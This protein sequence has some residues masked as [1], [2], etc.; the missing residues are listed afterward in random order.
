MKEDH[1]RK[2]KSN[3]DDFNKS[4]IDLIAKRVAYRCC[5]KG[6][7]IATIGP[8]Y[9]DK[10]KTTSIGVAC[11]ICAASPNG[12][13][14]DASMTP[15]QRKSADNGIWMCETH[16][17]LIDKDE[18]KYPV[19]V[20]REWKLAAEEMA[21]KELGNYK[22]TKV[23]LSD[24]Y[25]LSEIFKKFIIDGDYDVLLMVINE[26]KR[27][28][29][30]NEFILRYEV[31]YNAYCNREALTLS[32]EYYLK[33]VSERK[34]DEI[35]KV[36]VALNLKLGLEQLLPFCTNDEIKLLAKAILEGK[37]KNI[38]IRDRNEKSEN[39]IIHDSDTASK[40]LSLVIIE[41][42][43]YVL[44][45][46]IDGKKFKLV[47]S[48][49]LFKIYAHCWKLN[50]LIINNKCF[51]NKISDCDDYQLIKYSL[52]KIRQ[53]DKTIQAN[54]W[55]ICL[56]FVLG[57]RTEFEWLFMQC[58]DYIKYD[59]EVKK[60]YLN[61]QL[62]YCLV[63]PKDILLNLSFELDDES[64]IGVLE[65]VD[66]VCRKNFLEE[67]K[68]LLKKNS[69]FLYIWVKLINTTDNEKYKIVKSYELYYKNNF[70][71]NCMVALYASEDEQ[72]VIN[73][74]NK[75]ISTYY[76]SDIT[77][78]LEVLKKY[79]MWDKIKDLFS[80]DF[81]MDIKYSILLTL[82]C[83]DEIENNKHCL[84]LFAYLEKE[85][86]KTKG[87]Y[88]NYAVL[89][90]RL[91]ELEKARGCFQKEYDLYPEVGSLINL[92][93]SRNN[94]NYLIIDKYI[95]DACKVINSQVQFLVA[96]T[97]WRLGDI[98][99]VGEYIIRALL[100]DPNNKDALQMFSSYWLLFPK[101]DLGSVYTLQNDKDNIRIALLKEEFIS[102]ING[103]TIF[104][105]IVYN[106]SSLN[107]IHWK[108]LEVN[109]EVVYNNQSYKVI[110]IEPFFAILGHEAFNYTEKMGTIKAIRGNSPEDALLQ[111]KEIMTESENQ[112][113][114][115]FD[116]FN[117][118]H[119]VYPITM[120]SAQLGSCFYDTWR[121]V[122]TKNNLKIN[123]YSS[124]TSN[125]TFI[126]SIDAACTF[127][128]L[129]V[130][131]ELCLSS[132]LFEEHTKIKLVNILKD[133]IRFLRQDNTAGQLYCDN[134]EI[135]RVTYDKQYKKEACDNLARLI[136]TISNIKEISSEA[137]QFSDKEFDEFFIEY[138]LSTES[139]VLCLA[140]SNDYVI[141]TDE[142][143]MRMMCDKEH[144]QH[145]SAIELLLKNDLSCEKMFEYL[146]KI[147][148]TNFLNYFNINTLKRMIN[149]IQSEEK[150]V[151]DEIKRKIYKW[152]FAEKYSAE[153]AR[154]IFKACQ[155]LIKQEPN[156]KYSDAALEIAKHYFEELFPDE[157]RRIMGSLSASSITLHLE[158]S[159]D[160]SVDNEHDKTEE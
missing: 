21:A 100:I 80:L 59:S 17:H 72:A 41:N 11:H 2:K 138:E 48:E 122:V 43:N 5:Y 69:K 45:S 118:V 1:T 158:I 81:P 94:A 136:S 110:C 119:G 35:L 129:N 42:K 140:K 55:Y 105:I 8:K 60:T 126:L 62:N 123:N 88:Y 103:K 125:E 6:C 12:P 78:Y 63:D 28:D 85:G 9:G 19:E 159:N 131:D 148:K 20:L 114:T 95:D 96:L 120:L 74:L 56:N 37:V 52:S 73:W 66:D 147:E 141:V 155:E 26:L 30:E 33:H 31:I 76:F 83:C 145:V 32:I 70:L 53:L 113:A 117:Q 108:F 151:V 133:K 71:W 112:R 106:A 115:I 49:F 157:Y 4:T 135:K 87:F 144:I 14:Y 34:C 65:I 128:L 130:F 86:Y 67:H 116:I 154:N 61:Y 24:K 156:S 101:E 146:N 91:N 111:I 92:L 47:D 99:R 127:I 152:F 98:S 160:G 15:A 57:D 39:F 104:N 82:C 7:G 93:Q 153:H 25:F 23:Q 40:L 3:R 79:K 121:Y 90:N 13:R 102:G 97:Y 75:G 68:Y 36:L 54:V 18:I 109:D 149:Y 107:F 38:L 142:P 143:F 64:L 46:T 16:S 44:P 150:I 22:L 29:H 10:L 137:Y 77:I 134:G 58:P 50:N 124:N 84:T 132:L 139:K 51:N 89:Y 27:F